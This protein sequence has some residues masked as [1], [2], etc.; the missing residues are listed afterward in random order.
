MEEGELVAEIVI[1]GAGLTGL[2]A[3]YHLE[4]LGIFDYQIFEKN[5]RPGGLLQSVT[6]NGFTFDHTGHLLHISDPYFKS[7]LNE[8][9]DLDKNF[10]YINRRSSIFSNNVLTDYPFQMNMYGLPVNVIAE[11]IEGFIKRKISR[12]DPKNFHD[13]VLKH[14]GSGFGKHFFFPYNEKLLAYDIKKIHPSW[15]GRFVPSTNL[16]AIINGAIQKK[17]IEGVGYNSSF[18]YPKHG[19]IEFVIKQLVN[20]IKQNVM[21]EN[22]AIRINARKKI[23]TFSNGRQESFKYLISTIPLKDLLFMLE[24]P[25]SSKVTSAVPKLN[26][27]TVVNLNIG[28]DQQLEFDKHWIY[29]PEK[30]FPFYRLGFWHNVNPNMVPSGF[31]SVYVEASYLPD[32]TTNNQRDK[33]LLA[34]YEK[35]FSFLKMNKSSVVHEE[36]LTLKNAYVIYDSWREKNL[37]ALLHALN[38]MKM[39]SVGRFGEWKYSSMQEA[40][41]DGKKVADSIFCNKKDLYSINQNF[42]S[43]SFSG[44][45]KKEKPSVSNL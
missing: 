6:S 19:G 13:W 17:G 15:T 22:S 7:F 4:K 20:K 3:A 41:V 38:D 42:D 34:C 9:S 39:Y 24:E 40:V 36:V 31:S 26:C 37:S 11:C 32:K 29:T 21:T 23:I 18:Y 12:V 35:I 25:S 10:L 5:S 45:E 2:C 14:F 27:N 16:E 43:Q 30:Y 1:L 44:H 8:I 28:F 33:L